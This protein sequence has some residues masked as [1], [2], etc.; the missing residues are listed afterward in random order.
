MSIHHIVILKGYI[1]R[2][3]FGDMGPYPPPDQKLLSTQVLGLEQILVGGT[4]IAVSLVAGATTTK[5]NQIQG[6]VV[7]ASQ[8]TEE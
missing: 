8:S 2:R 4:I 1:L 5:P 7:A 6:S 3:L